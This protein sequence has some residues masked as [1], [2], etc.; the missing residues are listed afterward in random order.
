MM[1]ATQ[2][3][4]V[5]CDDL[6]V[7]RQPFNISGYH[8]VYKSTWR[9]G[10]YVFVGKAYLGRYTHA[11]EAAKAVVRWFK[12]RYGDGWVAAFRNRRKVDT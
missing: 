2:E 10:H 5:T 7:I 9:R 1:T 8:Y 3:A 4:E 6:A 12:D 11:R